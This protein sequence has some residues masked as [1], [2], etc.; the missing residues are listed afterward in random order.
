MATTPGT[1]GRPTNGLISK[2]NL[3]KII[4]GVAGAL[5][6]GLQG[7]SLSEVS[8]GNQNGER[9]MEMLEELLKISKDV[10]RS[11]DNQT[12]LLETME[13]S[14]TNQN[15]ILEN[16]SKNLA[17][18]EESLKQQGQILQTL[19]DAINERRELLKENKTQ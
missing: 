10:D 2:E 8:H 1:N 5:V 19:K 13:T 9:R 14:L 3:G 7:V 18:D 15:N 17:N 4:A 12:K 16:G 11:L 6:L